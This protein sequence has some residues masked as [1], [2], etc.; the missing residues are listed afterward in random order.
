MMVAFQLFLRIPTMLTVRSL[1]SIANVA[2]AL[3]EPEPL[4]LTRQRVKP[5]FPMSRNTSRRAVGSVIHG[6]WVK[7]ACAE[8]SNAA[9]SGFL[10]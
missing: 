1:T 5:N 9:A 2:Q 8:R 7:I 6:R 10:R 4:V 3:G